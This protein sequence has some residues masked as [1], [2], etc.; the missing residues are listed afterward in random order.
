MKRL[1]LVDNYDSFTYNLYQLLQ[2]NAPDTLIDVK[3]NDCFTLEEAQAYDG[4]VISPG[5]GVPEDAGLVLP[6]IRAAGKEKPIL[7]VCL[8][9]QA[10]C[11][12][13]GGALVNIPKV[14]HGIATE[15]RTEAGALL[16]KDLPPSLQAGRYHSWAVDE[17]TLPP[18]F[19]VTARDA[20]NMVMAMEHRAHRVAGVQFHPESI[21]TQYGREMVCNWLQATGLAA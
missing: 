14:C 19:R 17:S 7:G 11:I 21:L 1:L 2:D 3:R 12:A 15:I 5:P 16:F 10:I 8:G 18:C 6:L 13:Y 20:H 9:L 4:L